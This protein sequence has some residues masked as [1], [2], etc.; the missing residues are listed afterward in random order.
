M[1]AGRSLYGTLSEQLA[2]P[3][4]FASG[5]RRILEVRSRHGVATARQLDVPDVSN[6]AELIMVH[7]LA[8]G[9]LQITALNFCSDAITGSVRSE[10]L[11]AGAKLTDMFTGED[12][13]HVDDLQSFSLSID[14]YSGRSLLVTPQ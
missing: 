13:G 10:H 3:N 7:E 2:D 12:L 9:L 1:P 14:G 11:P 4:S 5:L 8:D 6:K